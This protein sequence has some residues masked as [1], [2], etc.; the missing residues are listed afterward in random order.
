MGHF[1]GHVPA[2]LYQNAI[3]WIFISSFFATAYRTAWSLTS[4][5][6]CFLKWLRVLFAAE[7]L[8][9]CLVLV[10]GLF[11]WNLKSQRCKNSHQMRVSDSDRWSPGVA[12][13]AGKLLVLLK[14]YLF[15]SV[16]LDHHRMDWVWMHQ[17][18]KWI[19]NTLWHNFSVEP[20][21]TINSLK[22]F[23][24]MLSWP[25]QRPR[26]RELLVAACRCLCADS[27]FDK[28]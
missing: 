7:G 5:L 27:V 3:R 11:K 16:G 23:F 19:K 12:A 25:R 20:P 15:S 2:I 22:A 14:C 24:W 26:R 9:S 1:F 21:S 18:E 10:W 17:R 6:C 28:N 4:S 8:K 13:A